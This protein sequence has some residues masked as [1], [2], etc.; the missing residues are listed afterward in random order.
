MPKIDRSALAR[1]SHV[2]DDRPYRDPA[3]L[4]QVRSRLRTEEQRAYFDFVCDLPYDFLIEHV[5]E[6]F[7]HERLSQHL[8][9]PQERIPSLNK[10]IRRAYRKQL[11]HAADLGEMP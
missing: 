4:Q 10:S 11:R 3:F 5:D 8:K 7:T 9:I 2:P 1:S 6:R